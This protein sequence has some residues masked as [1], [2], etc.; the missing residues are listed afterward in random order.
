MWIAENWK[1]YEVLDTSCGEKLERWGDYLLVR[2]D[3]QVIWDTPKT[4]K[5]WTRMNGHYHRSKKGGGE[6]EFFDLPEQWTIRYKTL[7]F[8]LKPFSFK[9]TG[10][11]PEQAANWDW[12]SDKIKK[13]HRP[14]KV[15]N[16]FAYTGGAT[17]AA[18]AAGASVTHVDASKGMVG[19][20]KENARSSH[21]ENASVRWIVDDCVKFVER[22]IRRGNHY[23]AII[24][25]PPSYGRGPK[26]EIWKIE[27]SI[28]PFIKLCTQLLSEDPLFFLVN[29]YT[30][31]LAPAVLTYMLS[32][33]LKDH[34]GRVD[35]QEVG[36]PVTSNGLVLPC[37]A[38]GRWES[39]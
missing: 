25:D 39:I 29:S 2:P 20:A 38:S 5:G 30:T 17:L 13:A 19:W 6:W 9:H 3:P 23:D 37:G 7:T 35:S 34:P 11:F 15:L 33:E 24:M 36:L 21:L 22:E 14:I 10:L 32:T 18:A 1:D 26:G 27:E 31:G 12:F 28:H 8:N 16:L 4:L